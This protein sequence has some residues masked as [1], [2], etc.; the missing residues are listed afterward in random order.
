MQTKLEK[1]Y[2]AQRR[3]GHVLNPV[4]GYP[5]SYGY[6]VKSAKYASG[7]H[8]GE[9][10]ACPVGTEIV[11]V[12]WGHVYA[13]GWSADG[14]GADYGNMVII[15]K[16]TGDYYYAYCHLSRIDVKP[17]QAVVPGMVLGRSGATGNVT[18]PHV[19]FEVRPLGGRYGT[20]VR[21]LKVKQGPKPKKKKTK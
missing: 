19:H 12:T 18:G 14:W 6:G 11:A 9:D 13:T 16:A 1:D 21:T 5:V 2:I 17:G 3:A 15:E 10:H 20:D 7:H 8:T 4:P